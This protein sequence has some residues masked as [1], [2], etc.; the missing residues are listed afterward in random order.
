MMRVGLCGPMIQFTARGLG[1]DPMPSTS[2]FYSV[3]PPLFAPIETSPSRDAI[4]ASI[5]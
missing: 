5:N 1:I 3:A 2:M 4:P